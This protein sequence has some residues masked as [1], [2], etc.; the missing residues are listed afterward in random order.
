MCRGRL[1]QEGR[2]LMLTKGA[3][4]RLASRGIQHGLLPG[5]VDLELHGLHLGPIEL[6]KREGG[7]GWEDYYR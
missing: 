1:L 5:D 2:N 7:R 3:P 4:N 6:R